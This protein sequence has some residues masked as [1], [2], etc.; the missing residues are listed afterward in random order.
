VNRTRKEEEEKDNAETQRAQ[1]FAE[2]TGARDERV[3][4]VK[5]GAESRCAGRPHKK[6]PRRRGVRDNLG[7]I[8]VGLGFKPANTEIGVPG[9]S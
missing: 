8:Y 2:K 6:Q 9:K 5:L 3:Y 7:S 1:R 4:P